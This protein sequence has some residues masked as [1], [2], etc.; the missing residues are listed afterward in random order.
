[1][2]TLRGTTLVIA[3]MMMCAAVAPPSTEQ[4]A[5]QR[6]ANLLALSAKLLC[7]GVFVVGRDP[8]EFIQ[9]NLQLPGPPI[10]NWDDVDVSID[11]EHKAV[12]LTL[13]GFEPRTAVFNGDQGCTLL[14][15]G[16]DRVFFEP[17][18]VPSSLPDPATQPWPMGDVLSDEPPPEVNRQALEEAL[19]F[20]FDNAAHR[21]PQNTRAMVVVYKGRIVAERYAPGFDKDTRHISWS[22]GKSITSALVGILV[23]DGHFRVEDPAPIAEWRDP[24]DPR[25]AIT[26][27]DL[28]HMSSGLKFESGSALDG[29]ALTDLDNHTYVYTGA[30]NVFEYSINR[31]LEFPPNT[32]WRYRNCDPLTLGK[33]IRDTVEARGEEYLSFPQRALFDRIGMRHMV[34]E[35]DPYG[36]FIMTGFDYGTARDWA[37]FGLLHLQ[38]GVWQGERILPE[39]WVDYVRTPAPAHPDKGYGALFWLN[40]GNDSEGLPEDLFRPAGHHG[41]AVLIVPSRHA[42][43]VR[44]G[45]SIDGGF[46]AY[47]E[48]VAGDILAVLGRPSPPS[49]GR[50]IER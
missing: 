9:D 13:D 49:G 46:D 28:L 50:A 34:L 20:A 25:S 21:I 48:K 26:I 12:T 44:L 17:V 14:P 22:M 36:N 24:A 7:S 39:G 18:E 42:V 27:D 6:T 3:A 43:I 8:G 35:T 10:V 37:R 38:D 16:A 31:E 41:Q 1:M 23:R 45:H 47:I 11:R 32:K 29:R 33:V 15:K 5:R 4:L 19:D 30:V 2:R 40:R